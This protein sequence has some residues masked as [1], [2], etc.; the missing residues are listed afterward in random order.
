[1]EKE[2]LGSRNR[3]ILLCDFSFQGASR[4]LFLRG[5][6]KACIKLYNVRKF[7]INVFKLIPPWVQAL[8]ALLS[9]IFSC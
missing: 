1:M 4:K 2:V 5:F 7:S 3:G 8:L 9:K 6:A